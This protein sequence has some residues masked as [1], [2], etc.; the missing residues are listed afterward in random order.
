M[1][2][3]KIRPAMPKRELVHSLEEIPMFASEDEERDW[4]AAH[5][6]SEEL[7]WSMEDTSERLRR[8]LKSKA[9]AP[10]KTP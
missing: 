3:L 7:L 5:E 9:T 1:K 6:L 2:P 8:L 4:W 10:R